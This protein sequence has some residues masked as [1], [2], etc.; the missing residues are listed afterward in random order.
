M[1]DWFWEFCPRCGASGKVIARIFLGSEPI[2]TD[3]TCT[4]CDGIGRVKVPTGFRLQPDPVVTYTT[5]NTTTGN[6]TTAATSDR[7][8]G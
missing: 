8:P 6:T 4:A 1:T 7:W 2:V 5:G 3:R